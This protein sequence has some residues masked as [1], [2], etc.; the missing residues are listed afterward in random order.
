[1][2]WEQSRQAD[3]STS[4]TRKVE[5]GCDRGCAAEAR[6]Y[7]PRLR[8]NLCHGCHDEL[9]RCELIVLREPGDTDEQAKQRVTDWIRTELR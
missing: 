1:M 3:G 8:E 7:I 9:V 6:W 2:S 4:T 5:G